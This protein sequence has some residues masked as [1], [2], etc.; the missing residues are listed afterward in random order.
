MNDELTTVTTSSAQ[1]KTQEVTRERTEITRE[2]DLASIRR[3]VD[4]SRKSGTISPELDKAIEQ[5]IDE[6]R[7]ETVDKGPHGSWLRG[8]FFKNGVFSKTA[9]ILVVAWVMGL[10]MW[11]TQ[12][13]MGGSTILGI[14]V[15]VFS[16]GDFLAVVGAASTLY[17]S[18]HNISVG[19]TESAS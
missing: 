6:D 12:G 2:Y 7:V 16:S 15:P 10:G 11:L 19:K 8:M 17:F 13:L 18:N 3:L 4:D 14:T 1:F 9:V 5:L